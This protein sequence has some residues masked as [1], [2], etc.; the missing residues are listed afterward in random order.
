M[1]E[2]Q[3]T[4]DREGFRDAPLR[5]TTLRGTV[6]PFRRPMDC[7]VSMPTILCK[8]E[9]RR[10]VGA[11]AMGTVYEAWDPFIKRRV[12]IKT[13]QLPRAADSETRQAIARFRREA[14]AAGGLA[15]PNIV[16]VY[17]YIETGGLACIV[18]EFVDGDS[19][20]IQLDR[21]EPFS[22][23]AIVRIMDGLL[24]G[25]QF[26][27]DH[28]VVHRDIKPSN[29]MLTR[30]GQAKLADFG[31][32]RIENSSLTEIGTTLGTP[33][34]MSPEQFMG[35]QIDARTDIYSARVLLFHLLTG[36]RP[37]QGHAIAIMY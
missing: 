13:V 37:F 9:I 14:E 10:E 36:V 19:L 11:G 2:V 25:L 1:K 7:A 27:H 23:P 15:H 22:V 6:G 35:Q 20:K 5:E 30:N 28:G 29:V 31:I 34:Y 17:D 21:E 24:S 33:A 26:S 16:T 4:E 12:A 18:M 3:S 32:A 8:Y